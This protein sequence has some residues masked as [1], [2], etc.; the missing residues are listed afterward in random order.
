MLR[1]V[2]LLLLSLPSLALGATSITQ[3]GITWTFDQNYTTG[4]F[5]N[6]DY[7]VVGT[8]SGVV[9]TGVSNTFHSGT[10]LSTVDHDGTDIDCDWTSSDTGPLQGLDD[11]AYVTSS[12]PYDSNLNVNHNLPY[13]VTGD[14]SVMSAISW[15]PTD[16]DTPY[17]AE[18]DRTRPKLKRIAVLTVLDSVPPTNSMRPSYAVGQKTL[19]SA[20]DI[21]ESLL[22]DLAV[23]VDTPS[24]SDSLEITSGV[25]VDLFQEYLSEYFR[26][27]DNFNT[28]ANVDEQGTYQAYQ[29]TRYL[30]SLMLLLLDENSVGDKTQLAVQITQIGIDYYGLL[31]NGATWP[32]NGGQQLGYKLPIIFAGYMLGNQ[33][34]MDI[35]KDYSATS[36]TFQEDC[37]HWYIESSDWGRVVEDT[38]AT[39]GIENITYNSLDHPVGTAEWGIRH[40]SY[41][42]QDNSN[43]IAR[44]RDINSRPNLAQSLVTRILGLSDKWNNLAIFDYVDRWLVLGGDFSNSFQQ[45]M[46]NAYNSQ[47]LLPTLS[48]PTTHSAFTLGG[49]YI[50]KLGD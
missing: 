17:S 25:W 18:Y 22:P 21:D 6:G 29:L 35:G 44:Y 24:M 19:Y 37:N 47:Y 23:V 8:G 33:D 50:L 2:V 39:Y 49:V 28:V 11:D 43:F 16:P 42:E 30:D 46:W 32:A 5:A 9:I 45:N 38:F 20:N 15:L 12:A 10:D 1:L 48:P 4:Q 3:H 41:P 34:M 7:Y 31:Q 36:N 27:T 13:T 40:C 26:P 14:K